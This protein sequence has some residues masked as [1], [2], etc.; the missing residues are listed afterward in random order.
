M[1]TDWPRYNAALT[2]AIGEAPGAFELSGYH[3]HLTLA[4]SWRP[5]RGTWQAAQASA[6]AEFADL[7]DT[8][9][10]FEVREVALFEKDAPGQP[11]RVA[12]RWAL[13]VGS[14]KWEVETDSAG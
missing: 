13:A 14:G 3:P 9:L 12:E 1:A 7:E 11:Y 5:L 10:R 2:G 4:L 6:L 8:P